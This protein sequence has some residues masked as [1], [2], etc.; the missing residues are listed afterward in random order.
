MFSDWGELIFRFIFG[1]VI[2]SAFA[3]LAEVFRPKSF[4]GLFGA[5]PSI[6]LATMG[7]TIAQ[8]GKAYAGLEARSMVFGAM[9]F[10]C[11][12]SAASWL[13]MRFKPRAIVATVALLPVWLGASLGFLWLATRF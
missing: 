7:I 2:V 3:V 1:G 12:A 5:A 9:A 8:H 11:Y 10:F 4:A 6:A 13:L